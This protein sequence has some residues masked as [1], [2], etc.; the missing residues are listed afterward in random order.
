[1]ALSDDTRNELEQYLKNWI[2]KLT[3]EKTKKYSEPSVSKDAKYKP[4]HETHLPKHVLRAFD[5][6]RSF[7]TGLGSVFEECGKIIAQTRFVEV[8]RQFKVESFV[9]ANTINEVSK[10]IDEL[11]KKKKFTNYQH[12]VKRIVGLANNDTSSN[13][14]QSVI[15]D[16][17]V[18][19]KDGNETYFEMKS[20]KPN[21][22]QCLEVTRQ[23]MLIHC[24]RKKSFPQVKT[25]WGMGYNPNG[26]GNPYEHG[27]S[28]AYLDIKHHVVVG[29]EFWDYLGGHG[30][31]E[32]LL[33]IF[34]KV[35]HDM[36]IDLIKK[37]LDS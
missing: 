1:M 3:I 25:F 28:K 8:K 17:Y 33:S 21:K 14:S 36:G 20:P 10:V 37:T 6:E 12:E 22:K 27:L 15:V 34:E 31:Y 30:T 4:F 18:K 19:D 32:E 2:K 5:F 13:V 23:H 35:G 11:D 29:K 7:S 26:E 9:P 24:I 16:L